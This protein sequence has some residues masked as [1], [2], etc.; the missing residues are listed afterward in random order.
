MVTPR[1]GDVQAVAK[2]C[3]CSTRHVYRLSDAWK[4]PRP[5][6]LGALSRWNLTEVED[7][8]SAGCPAVRTV[9]GKAVRA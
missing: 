5:I 3:D 4:M 9:K 2:I 8:I 7:W 1:M 6:K